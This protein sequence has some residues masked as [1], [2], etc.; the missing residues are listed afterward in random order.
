[1]QEENVRKCFDKDIKVTLDIVLATVREFESSMLDTQLVARIFILRNFT[2]EGVE[3]Y[4]KFHLY[5][6]GVRPVISF[7]GYDLIEQDLIMD[8]SMLHDFKPDVV[9]VGIVLDT[10]DKNYG[11]P[12]WQC[13]QAM[14]RLQSIF[15]LVSQKIKVPVIVNTFIPP[16]Y[17]EH[18]LFAPPD[19][20]DMYSQVSKLNHFIR[21]YVRNNSFQFILADWERC[22]CIVGEKMAIDYRSW[23]L[24]KA[25]FHTGFLNVVGEGMAHAVRLLKGNVKKCLV[26]DCD[27]TLWGGVV[28]EDGLEGIKLDSN[29]YPG[30]VYYDFQRSVIHLAGRGVMVALCSKNNEEDVWKVLRD[31]P[32]CLLKRNN[33]VAWKINWND[34]VT[35]LRKLAV[36]LNIGLD[37]IV[38]VDDSPT[39]CEY[40]RQAL[41]EVTILLVPK[42][43]QYFPNML[44]RLGLFGTLTLSKEDHERVVQYQHVVKRQELMAECQ[45]IEV[46]IASLD[47]ICDVRN[48]DF[49]DISR[50]AQLTQKTNQFNLT[51]HRYSETEVTSMLSSQECSVYTL[52][53]SDKFGEYGLS[54]VLIARWEERKVLIDTLLLS[55]RVLGRNVER[56][57]VAECLKRLVSERNVEVWEA[58]YV[59][60]KKNVQVADFWESLGFDVVAENG[61]RKVYRKD[62]NKLQL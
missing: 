50:V 1:M 11:I 55:C 19:Y 42:K 4:L 20:S 33:L 61:V 40:I 22:L 6:W 62:A 44:F 17:S 51:I 43:L 16:L 7:G 57:F 3:P 56:S 59:F 36:E 48:L 52:R 2:F 58:E 38:F 26:L 10:L 9:V 21:D 27:N 23:Y 15:A 32:Y 13:T 34:K 53:V 8:R 12:G 41:P 28:G 49:K 45:N 24:H 54:G 60:S 18:G 5:H 14:E 46:F 29:S 35:N 30:Q 25:P 37:S 47:L 39:E 31:H